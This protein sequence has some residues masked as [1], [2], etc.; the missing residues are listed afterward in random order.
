MKSKKTS[1]TP[2]SIEANI[3]KAVIYQAKNGAI[4]LRGDIRQETI[5]A[6]RMQMSEIF[7]VNTQAISKHINNIYREEELKRGATSSKM[8]LVQNESGRVVRRDVDIYNLEVLI[9]TGYRI[10]SVTGTHF[11]QWATKTLKEHIIKGYTID[12][13][14]VAKNYE[15]FLKT[16]NDIQDILPSVVA[17][18]NKSVLDLVKEYANTWMSLDAYDKEELDTFKK[19]K[20]VV[21]LT[22]KELTD[23]I[24]G[25]K[26]ELMKKK[27]ATDIFAQERNIKSIE[28]IVGNVM[29]SIAGRD[30]YESVEEKAAHLLYFMTKNHPFVDGNKRSGAFSFVWFL[31][32]TKSKALKNINSN[33]LTTLTLLIAESNPRKKEQTV[34]LITQMLK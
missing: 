12:R 3:N 24:Q 22:G 8:E 18:D 13:K 15:A 34:A 5:W 21:K 25:L 28:G 10:S 19:T 23:A 33:V 2:K 27:E 6:T 7:G 20:K 14:R 1:K 30:V 4:E 9:A 26:T 11:R 17:V 31:S 29:Q 16:V 32:K